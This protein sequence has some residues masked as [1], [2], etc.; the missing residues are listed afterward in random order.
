MDNKKKSIMITVAVII[1]II[2]LGGAGY[3]YMSANKDDKMQKNDTKMSKEDKKEDKMK[4]DSMD[5]DHE[6]EKDSMKKDSMD[7][8][9]DHKMDKEDMSMEKNGEYISLDDYNAHKDMYKDTTTVYFF[10]ANWCPICVGIDNELNSDKSMIPA[11]TVIVKTDF[12]S[13]KDLRKKYGVTAQT[14]FVQVDKDGNKVNMWTANS[15]KDAVE[16][17]EKQ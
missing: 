13:A 15:A 1:G 14:S 3:A 11:K 10:H 12:D 9:K 8:D 16:K 6:M 17:I 2:I 7:K 5:K 4:K